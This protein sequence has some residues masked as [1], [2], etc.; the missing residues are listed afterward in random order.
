MKHVSE[1]LCE[2]YKASWAEAL[3]TSTAQDR[4]R[5][6]DLHRLGLENSPDKTSE[7]TPSSLERED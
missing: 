4:T 3:R 7:N 2:H 5:R 1:A 6:D